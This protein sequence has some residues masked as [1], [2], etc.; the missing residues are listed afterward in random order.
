MKN[1]REIRWLQL[2]DLNKVTPDKL[3]EFGKILCDNFAET[4]DF[5][6]ITGDL[7]NDEDQFDRVLEFLN[8][9]AEVIDKKNIIIIA[10]DSDAD[11]SDSTVKETIDQV[12]K[13]IGNNSVLQL[14]Q[15]ERENLI[16]SFLKHFNFLGK[17]Y[18][19]SLDFESL[20]ERIYVCENTI[21]LMCINTAYISND[22][23][24]EKQVID[25]QEIRK[26][27]NMRYPCIAIMHHDYYEINEA[28]GNHLRRKLSEL[29]VS[30]I[31]CGHKFENTPDY[32]ELENGTRIPICCCMKSERRSDALSINFGVYEYRWEIDARSV[33]LNL[34]EWHSAKLTFKIVGSGEFKLRDFHPVR[35]LNKN[36]V[37]QQINIPDIKPKGSTSQNTHHINSKKPEGLC[38]YFKGL[39]VIIASVVITL[40]LICIFMSGRTELHIRFKETIQDNIFVF[41]NSKKISEAWIQTVGQIVII[42]K[43][44]EIIK[45]YLVDEM[46]EKST[47]IS[48]TKELEIKRLEC[49]LADSCIFKFK[50]ELETLLMQEGYDKDVITVRGIGFLAIS[51]PTSTKDNWIP[52]YYILDDNSLIPLSSEQAEAKM[53]GTEITDEIWSSAGKQRTLLAEFKTCVLQ[54][55]EEMSD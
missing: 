23:H 55:L 13:K 9:L 7:Y 25:L 54:E 30:A 14:T 37:R 18:G 29:G 48:S 39:I 19:E 43:D 6:L 3:R 28:Q 50:Q 22:N 20:Y 38:A 11:Y 33:Q 51:L 4:I 2:P 16:L 35:P 44:G 40:L 26:L 5:V 34:Y 53:G 31:L 47:Y 49:P 8:K 45:T 27:Q 36:K 32:V 15:S 41:T 52:Y 42:T 46:Y 17:F 21:A 24:I 12:R 1:T 10:G